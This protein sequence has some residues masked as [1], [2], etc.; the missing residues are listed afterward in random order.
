MALTKVDDRGL[1]T[2]INLIDNEKLTLG[3]GSDFEMFHNGNH[4]FLQDVGTGN[5]YINSTNGNLHLRT[6][7]NEQAVTC[8]QDAEVVLYYNND[9]RFETKSDGA[10]FTG[11]LYANDNEKIRLGTG[12]DLEIY[13]SG[14]HSF[15]KDAGT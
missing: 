6:N 10:R 11:H 2:P 9:R 13:H 1:N 8:V 12:H 7:S 5:L 14:S 4:S 3:T 15:I